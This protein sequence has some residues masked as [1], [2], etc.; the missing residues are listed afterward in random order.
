MF[1]ITNDILTAYMMFVST[2]D[3][4]TEWQ[5]AYIF[6]KIEFLKILVQ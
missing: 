6:L 1:D 4:N 5:A 2:K 3:S